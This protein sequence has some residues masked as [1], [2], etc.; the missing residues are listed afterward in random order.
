MRLFGKVIEDRGDRVLIEIRNKL[1]VGDNLELII[2]NMINP[3]EFENRI[4][5]KSGKHTIYERAIK[6]LKKKETV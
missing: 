1:S 3:F 5:T 6:N 4:I 2:P